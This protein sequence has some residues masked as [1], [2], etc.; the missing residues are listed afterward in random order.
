VRAIR[1]GAD[2]GWAG[3]VFVA[4]SESYAHPSYKARLIAAKRPNETCFTTR[5]GP[6]WAAQQQRVLRNLATS[7]APSALPESIGNTTLFP[8]VIDA[9]YPM[10][11]YS[12]I[13]PTRDT[14]GDFDQMDMPAGSKSIRAIRCVRPA[15][16]IIDDFIEGS[17]GA[18]DRDDDES[19]DDD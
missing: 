19:L 1:A 16:E 7:E 17:R 18:C 11:K 15:A 2:G 8:G 9:P 14:V 6:E 12:A 13:V 5:F 3:T 4:A 10:P